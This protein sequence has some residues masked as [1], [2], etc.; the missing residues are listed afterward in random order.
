MVMGIPMSHHVV[1]VWQTVVRHGP[2][3]GDQIIGL[4]PSNFE[5]FQAHDLVALVRAYA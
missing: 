4:D 5:D 2:P 1:Q 3:N